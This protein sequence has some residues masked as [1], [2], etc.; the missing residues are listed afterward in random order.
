[1]KSFFEIS[2]ESFFEKDRKILFGKGVCGVVGKK[3]IFFLD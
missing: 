3:I 1:M 2:G